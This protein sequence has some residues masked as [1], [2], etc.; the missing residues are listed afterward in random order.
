M[1]H[2]CNRKEDLRPT[3]AIS[4]PSEPARTCEGPGRL[5]PPFDK[6]QGGERSAD[7][8]DELVGIRCGAFGHEGVGHAG[9]EARRQRGSHD[10]DRVDVVVLKRLGTPECSRSEVRLADLLEYLTCC[11]QRA[12]RLVFI[13]TAVDRREHRLQQVAGM[14]GVSELAVRDGQASSLGRAAVGLDTQDP[15]AGCTRRA[16]KRSWG[17]GCWA[18]RS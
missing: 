10:A 8:G 7:L 14:G 15:Q 6:S 5:F 1:S 17:S 11:R 2:T 18:P 3:P 12:E 13:Q 9:T 16:S 4:G